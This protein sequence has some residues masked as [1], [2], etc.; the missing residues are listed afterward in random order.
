MV[1]TVTILLG[2]GSG[3]FYPATKSPFASNV[4]P[5]YIAAADFN[6]DGIPDVAVAAFIGFYGN[7]YLLSGGGGGFPAIRTTASLPL[8]RTCTGPSIAKARWSWASSS[9]RTFAW[10]GGVVDTL[11][12][13]ETNLYILPLHIR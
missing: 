1:S 6:T 5:I 4:S 8:R 9:P 12:K 13:P 11:S 2:D 7:V 10:Q 3:K